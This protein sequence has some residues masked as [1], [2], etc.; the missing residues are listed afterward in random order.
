[1]EEEHFKKYF[2]W[3]IIFIMAVIS[4]LIIE[5]FITAIL[6]AF[7][8]AYLVLPIQKVLSKKINKNIS[9]LI[10]I[11]VIALFLIGAVFFAVQ[12]LLNQGSQYLTSENLERISGNVV[13][14]TDWLGIS[15]RFQSYL[16]TLIEKA[17]T[18]LL[19]ILSSIPG[20]GFTIFLTLFI[21]YFLIADWQKISSHIKSILPF[22]NREKMLNKFG[23][24]S[25]KIVYGILL[26]AIIEFLIA[27][28]GFWISG[29]NFF[30]LFAFLIALAVFI[31]LLG[32]LVI[33][34]PLAIV[35]I[36]QGN[37]PSAIGVI[38]TGLI[39][40][41]LIDG[42]LSSVIVGKKAKIHPVTHLL[43]VLGGVSL[44]G[45]FGFIIGPLILTFMIDFIEAYSS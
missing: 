16:P 15:E 6:S 29:V 39:I 20:I 43:G 35:L 40:S 31:P 2:F 12:S 17:G 44:F 10:I 41:L 26:I 1:M 33:W 19:S 28:L 34:G 11:L 7:I 32:P 45:F 27:S 42:L 22:K 36:I 30:F 21:A 37:Y 9:A 14:L 5:S 13:K 8:L 25:G 38:I 4:Y 18:I 23:S 24:T 3:A